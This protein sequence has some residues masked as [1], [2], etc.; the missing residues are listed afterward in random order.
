[1]PNREPFDRLCRSL[2]AACGA[3]VLPFFLRVQQAHAQTAD[4]GKL[5]IGIIGSGHSGGTVGGL[6]VEAG[7]PVLFA[8]RHPEEIKDLVARLDPL[9][10]VGTVAQAIAFGDAMFV[11]VP[12]GALPTLG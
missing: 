12:Y 2:L 8:S 1:M 3:L 7:H 6:W 4:V 5:R 9:A 10:R 11:A